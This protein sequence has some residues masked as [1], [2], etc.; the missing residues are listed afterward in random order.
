MTI[1]DLYSQALSLP[2]ADREAL[3]FKL[4]ASIP[5][6]EDSDSFAADAQLVDEISQRISDR[7]TGC[8]N[9]G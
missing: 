3:A 2:P 4:L 6:S 1:A 9:Y 7:D 5:G 8:A